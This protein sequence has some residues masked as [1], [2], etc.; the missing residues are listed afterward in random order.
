MPDCADP[1]CGWSL[2]EVDKTPIGLATSDIYGKLFYYVRSMLEK[3]M[4]RMS[5]SAIAFQLLQVHAATLP[6]HL[7]ESFDR[8][9]VSN[10]SDSGYLGAHRTVALVA[11]LLR[12]PPTNPHAI[13]ITLFMNLIDEN[14]TLQDQTTEWTLGSLS[15][16]RL[17]NYLL[18]TRPNRSIIEPALMKYAHARHHMR[19]YDDIF[20]RCVDKLQLARMPDWAGA[21]MKEE[22]AII[23]KWPHR[24]KLEPGQEGGSEEFYRLMTSGLS[25]RELYLEWKRVQTQKAGLESGADRETIMSLDSCI[26][27]VRILV[28]YY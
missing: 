8:I 12:A 13:L 9:D 19:E 7:D 26:A 22:H 24:L 2:H 10:I 17:A 14:F 11:P 1:L 16:K 23:E 3:F 15:T 25:S 5:K 20:G 18:P 27:F 4:Y 21:V 28:N 6:N